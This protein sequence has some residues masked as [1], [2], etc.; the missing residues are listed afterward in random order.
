MARRPMFAWMLGLSLVTLM[1]VLLYPA[2]ATDIA[3]S[4]RLLENF[5]PQ[6][7]NVLGLSLETFSSFLGFYAYAC[8][9]IGLAGAVQATT[10]GIMM[11]GREQL[12]KTTE[13]LLT[14]PV[15]RTQI[16]LGK[17]ISAMV[18]IILT[19]IALSTATIL[20]A[21]AIGAGGSFSLRIF[22]L[23]GVVFL[24]LQLVFLGIGALVSQLL[25]RVKSVVYVSLAVVLGFFILSL[26]QGL[27]GDEIL[28]YLT[29]FRYFDHLKIVTDR[30]IDPASICL[31]GTVAIVSLLIAYSLFRSRDIRSAS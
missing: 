14:R 12:S 6:V 20:F 17:L 22:G 27:S 5:P 31:S 29:P 13:F 26:L 19:N 30:T 1:F 11:L 10:L 28:R 15:T 24:L 3:S 4:K 8:M 16:F 2:F 7:R 9:Y 18:V 21:F 25:P 23:L